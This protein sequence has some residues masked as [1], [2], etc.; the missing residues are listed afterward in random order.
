MNN[1]QD[2]VAGST[3]RWVKISAQDVGTQIK[4]NVTDSGGGI[5]REVA[6]RLFRPFFS[7]KG[8]KGTGLGLGISRKIIE[9]HGGRL[10]LDASCAN[11]RFTIT[12]PKAQV[13]AR[14]A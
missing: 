1:A 6:D 13:L 10:V 2:A 7:T 5:P 12:L 14:A 9:A 8:N 3:E 11:T 4:I